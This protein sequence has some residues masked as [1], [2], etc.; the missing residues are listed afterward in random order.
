MLEVVF[1]THAKDLRAV[2]QARRAALYENGSL[3]LPPAETQRKVRLLAGARHERRKTR[4]GQVWAL[5]R[6]GWPREMIGS[7]LGISRATVYR[8]LRS[9]ALPERQLLTGL[10]RQRS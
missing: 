6:Q 2:E 8:Y 9:E 4:H 5:S 3:P 1:T 10:V 7:R